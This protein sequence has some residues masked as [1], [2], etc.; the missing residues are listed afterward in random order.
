M[1]I[2]NLLY[3]LTAVDRM[4]WLFNNLRF[5][6]PLPKNVRLIQRTRRSTL[7][8]KLQVLRVGKLMSHLTVL[9]AP[10]TR[11]STCSLDAWDRA[12]GEVSPGGNGRKRMTA[13]MVL[14]VLG[15]H[16]QPSAV[17]R[18]SWSAITRAPTFAN[19]QQLQIRKRGTKQLSVYTEVKV[20]S[21]VAST[22]DTRVRV[23]AKR[24]LR[25]WNTAGCHPS[26]ERYDAY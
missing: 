19:D 3:N 18:R 10:T 7:S 8:L 21:G 22:C 15:C 6:H 12:C 16:W 1:T 4:E 20:S 17:S 24:P 5:R 14:R 13:A 9:Y 25:E 23:S 2:G 26:A 11:G